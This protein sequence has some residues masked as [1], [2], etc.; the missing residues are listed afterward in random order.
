M[1]ENRFVD[2]FV[3][4][5]LPTLEDRRLQPA[6]L[7]Y[8]VKVSSQKAPIVEIAVIN[9]TEGETPPEGYES[10]DF[11]PYGLPANLNHG[12]LRAPQM[13][14][15]VRRGHDKPPIMDIGCV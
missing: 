6:D 12:S 10:I 1:E 11:T 3:V 8:P 2:Y 9:K 4:A 5:G 14:L 13:H 7:F 15:C